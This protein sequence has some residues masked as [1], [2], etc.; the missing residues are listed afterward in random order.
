MFE[1]A[2]YF[3]NSIPQY[4]G[5]GLLGLLVTVSGGLIVG[6]FSSN[7]FS[8]ISEVTRVE[9]LLLE[10]KIPIYKEIYSRAE[11]LNQMMSYQHSDLK[12]IIE[13]IKECG[14]DFTERRSYQVNEIFKD[15]NLC[16]D[17]VLEL[18]KY[19]A[20]N[21]IYYN[22]DI[23]KQLLIFQNYIIFYN[24]FRVI[25]REGVYEMRKDIDHNTL[26][27]IE[28]SMFLA[29]GL[30]LSEDFSQQVSDVIKCLRRNINNVSLKNRTPVD[31]TY[32]YFN[33]ENSF[34]MKGL[35]ESVLI[36]ERSKIKELLTKFCCIAISEGLFGGE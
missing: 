17:T 5:E 11:N 22:D 12:L 19:I 35:K 25:Y 20:E 29:L 24:R 2:I 32:E 16:C 15:A 23:F 28:N 13:Q 33:G 36:K 10:K 4:I 18:D 14:F 34:I 1:K 31:Y 8:R 27:K 7:Y 30:V 9:G 26:V 6:Y 3:F 21:R